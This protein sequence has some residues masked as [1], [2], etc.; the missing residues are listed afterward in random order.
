MKGELTKAIMSYQLALKLNSD[1]AECH[2]N[3]ATAYNDNQQ[4]QQAKEHFTL[5]LEHNPKNADCLYELGKLQQLR[6]QVNVE[7][8]EDFYQRAI[9]VDPN[10]GKALVALKQI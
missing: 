6:G 7:A 1:S 2:F 5:S 9:K 4:Y 10:H 8:A 3:I